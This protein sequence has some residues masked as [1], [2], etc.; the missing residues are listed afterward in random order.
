MLQRNWWSNPVSGESKR[1]VRLGMV[2]LTD[3][4][5]I[6]HAQAAGLF[7]QEGLEAEISV[8]P[9][10]ANVA[11]KL[12]WGLLDGAVMLPPLAIAMSLGLRGPPAPLF[13]PAGI[14][15]NGNA[16]TL[17]SALAAPLL[18]DGRGTA[19]QMAGRLHAALPA[20]PLRLA[21]VHGFSTH[22]LLLRLFLESG[23]FD[24]AHVAFSVLPPPDM[25]AALAAGIVDGFCAGA[26]WGSVAASLG[27]G[28][29][30]ALT[31][32][33]WRDHPEKCLAV[34]AAWADA[35]P[36][37]LHA[38]VRAVLR[39]GQDCDDP[40]HTP[41]LA[42]LLAYPEWVGVPSA[43]IA[44]SL[45]GGEGGESDRSVFAAHWAGVPFPAHGRWFLQQMAR[46][47]SVPPGAEETA[48][49]MYRPDIYSLAATSLGLPPPPERLAAP[50]PF[51]VG[52][53]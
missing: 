29:T 19:P 27:A 46:W 4:A 9:S 10:W 23:G 40:A 12:A 7:A 24:P 49:A 8:E 25:P 37:L 36:G 50:P 33:I 47:R 20:R 3:A 13:V 6:V 39:A 51:A 2:R 44:A 31:S 11:D 38:L 26:P 17:A 32:G 15:L 52:S 28:R 48:A 43:L 5:P 34:S 30:V 1:R 14:S 53:E 16:I 18:R 42:R 21:V 41:S 45:P 35:N 22:D